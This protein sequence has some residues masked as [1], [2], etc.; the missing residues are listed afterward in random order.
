MVERLTRAALGGGH[1]LG[2][3]SPWW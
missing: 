2:A 3:R 1:R